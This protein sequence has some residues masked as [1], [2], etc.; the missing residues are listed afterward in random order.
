MTR[1]TINITFRFLP[2]TSTPC[3]CLLIHPV[4]PHCVHTGASS[5]LAHGLLLFTIC[6]LLTS[7]NSICTTIHTHI[8]TVHVGMP[9]TIRLGVISSHGYISLFLGC[10]SL[11]FFFGWSN[12]CQH[13]LLAEETVIEGDL[14]QLPFPGPGTLFISSAK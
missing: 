11:S 2:S 8:G 5:R 3:L 4:A 7:R 9:N 12:C 6:I 13:L 1:S 14:L 10:S